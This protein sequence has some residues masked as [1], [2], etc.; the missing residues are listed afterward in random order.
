MRLLSTP[1]A[2]LRTPQ[3]WLVL[4]NSCALT[5]T[6]RR[7]EGQSFDGPP[8]EALQQHA[9]ASDFP[10]LE[11]DVAA[12]RDNARESTKQSRTICDH[13]A[14]PR[15]A[16]IFTAFVSIPA[17]Q[18]RN[19]LSAAYCTMSRNGGDV[20]ISRAEALA[21]NGECAASPS[22]RSRDDEAAADR[23]PAARAISSRS[24]WRHR[25]A[26]ASVRASR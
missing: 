26:A 24:I 18:S 16:E 22:P 12:G 7:A 11:G 13:A 5:R 25:A 23:P 20:T 4:V 21:M 15:C 8:N 17:N 1:F 2:L 19:Q 14:S 6:N 10:D 3:Q 9:A